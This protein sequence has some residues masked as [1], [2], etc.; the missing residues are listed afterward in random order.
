[1]SGP[2]Y[3][4]RSDKHRAHNLLKPVDC[5]MVQGEGYLDMSDIY[6]SRDETGSLC[7][8]DLYSSIRYEIP[9]INVSESSSLYT[10][11]TS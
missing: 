1:M 2:F 9:Y 4:E 6:P 10:R 11:N 5:T 3:L 8:P 7:R